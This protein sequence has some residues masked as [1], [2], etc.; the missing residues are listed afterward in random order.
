[1]EKQNKTENKKSFIRLF[2][3]DFSMNPNIYN[4]INGDKCYFLS[5]HKEDIMT[6]CIKGFC[7]NFSIRY[8]IDQIA[9]NYNMT[10][11]F[12]ESFEIEI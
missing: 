8:K 11:Y 1:M 2:E 12:D 5:Y 7:K 3:R 10:L 4:N 9:K 6:E